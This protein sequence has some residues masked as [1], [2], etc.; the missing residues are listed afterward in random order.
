VPAAP[1]ASEVVVDKEY[2]AAL[3]DAVELPDI[4]AAER[5]AVVVVMLVRPC[6]TSVFDMV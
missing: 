2:A 3:V 4:V 5:A 1:A 6:L